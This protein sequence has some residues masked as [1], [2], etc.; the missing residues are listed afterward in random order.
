MP[1][2]WASLTGQQ[3]I[4]Q[5]AQARV[6]LPPGQ[7]AVLVVGAGAEQHGTPFLE[8]VQPPAEFD[9][10]GRTDKREILGV[11]HEH[12]PLVGI[13]L[14]GDLGNP[15]LR[16][17][18][19]GFHPELRPLGAYCKHGSSPTNANHTSA[20]THSSEAHWMPKEARAKISLKPQETGCLWI[21]MLRRIDGRCRER[22]N[23]VGGL[24]PMYRGSVSLGR[25]GV[26]AAAV[27]HTEASTINGH[28]GRSDRS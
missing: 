19:T 9:Q 18:V 22:N 26:Q 5:I 21:A 16:D 1:S 24:D 14:V 28:F 3:R 8:L 27:R 15:V 25:T 20:R 17:A 13:G 6:A 4:G 7:M 12:Q 10:L 11:E 2:S 23:M